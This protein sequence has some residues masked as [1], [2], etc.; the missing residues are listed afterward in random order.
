MKKL[1]VR[2]LAETVLVLFGVTVITFLMMHYAPG[3]PL[4]T[5]PEL[6]L[7][8]TAIERWLAV[9]G[10]DKPIGAQYIA[11]LSRLIRG[12]L[13]TSLI[14]NRPV[15]E[16]IAERLPATLIL[17]VTAFVVSFGLA[18]ILGI[19]TASKPG[20]LPDKIIA[21]FSLVGVSLPGFWLC[22]LA[23]MLF[24]HRLRWLPAAGI[25]S[26]GE[27]NLA[28]LVRHMV[29][30]VSVLAVSGFAH[31]VRYVRYTVLE[32]LTKEYVRT[33]RAK[34][35]SRKAILSRHILPAAAIPLVT[36][37]ALSLPFLFTGAAVVESF[38]GWPGMGRWIITSTLARDYPAIM[39]SNLLVAILVAVSGLLADLIY[40]LLDPRIRVGH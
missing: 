16:L 26:P 27:G 37:A 22:M 18:A 24:A 20:S 7:D 28:D 38:F 8:P 29:L 1:I 3:Q 4:Q 34:G 31:Y 32:V 9:R 2:R 21:A 14:Y 13:G 23:V 5:N 40:M 33:A 36:V 6:R 10:L 17:T 25:M 15:W 19:K 30:P 39:A 11:W 35:L 12:D